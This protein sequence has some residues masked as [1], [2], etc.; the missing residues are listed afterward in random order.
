MN[1]K[2]ESSKQSKISEDLDPVI[3]NLGKKK[4]KDIK[5]LKKGK[6]KLYAK[7]MDV[8]SQLESNGLADETGPVV[9]L[10]KEKKRKNKNSFGFP[11]MNW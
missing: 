2:I 11:G 5:K 7:V 9:V 6:G 8:Q 1:T 4:R 10:V 3:V